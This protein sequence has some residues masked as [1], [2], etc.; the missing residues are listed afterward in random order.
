MKKIISFVG[1]LFAIIATANAQIR[2]YDVLPLQNDKVIYTGV[3]RVDSANKTELY[4]RA[5]RWLV[6]EYKSAKEVVQLDD[7]EN[8]DIIGKGFYLTTWCGERFDVYHTITIAV[9]DGRYKYTITDLTCKRYGAATFKEKP[10]E[11]FWEYRAK[12]P[13]KKYFISVDKEIQDAIASLAKFMTTNPK[14]NW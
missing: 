13:T 12:N 11:Y 4:D 2:V 9:K 3:V 8:G 14:G 5:K 1:L 6:H 10:I 7:K